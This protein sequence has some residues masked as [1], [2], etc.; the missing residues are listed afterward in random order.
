MDLLR[1]KQRAR[2]HHRAMGGGDSSS[3][4]TQNTDYRYSDSRSVTST[5]NRNYTDSR[6]DSRAYANS[7]NTT[8]TINAMD[9]GAIAAGSAVS[10]EALK[11]NSL[12]TL[13]MFSVAE[14]LFAGTANI[15]QA[16]T[17][18]AEN[19]SANATQAY[20]DATAQATGNKTMMLAGLAV[21]G[22]VGVMAFG[23]N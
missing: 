18:L 7:G 2:G 22:V 17:N 21:V 11:Q 12:N 5:D 14:K 23:K 19:L 6:Q 16:N 15:M 1:E 20:G 13:A 10:V 9:G 4:S 8:T 3:A